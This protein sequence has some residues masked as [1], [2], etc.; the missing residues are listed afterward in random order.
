MTYSGGWMNF[1]DN[2]NLI[3]ELSILAKSPQLLVMLDFDGTISPIVSTPVE[4]EIDREIEEIL[5]E[6][7]KLPSTDIWIV[8]GRS[9]SDLKNKVA[10]N[11]LI[12]SHGIECPFFDEEKI[13]CDDLIRLKNNMECLLMNYRGVHIEQKAYSVSV[14][15]RNADSID[16][17]TI[18]KIVKDNSGDFNITE[19]KKVIELKANGRNK[20][21][22]CRMLL[23]HCKCRSSIYVGDD[24]T[25]E[26][27]FRA[28][29]EKS[30]T[31]K[32]GEG[33]T[34]AKYMLRNID[35]LRLLLKKLLDERRYF[36]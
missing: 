31:V 24:I 13:D 8:S 27:A 9:L 28:L 16:E 5:T 15:Y 32:I 25:D 21:D 4:A 23:D 26:D 11:N 10:F 18:K 29:K 3:A 7:E 19:G 33:K 2:G 6:L 22:A 17:E 36:N 12:G 20:G 1:S 34:N 14:H 35:D 30:V